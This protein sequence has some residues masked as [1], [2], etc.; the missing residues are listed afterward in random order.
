[1]L[2][3]ARKSRAAL[4]EL[5]ESIDPQRPANRSLME[6]YETQTMIRP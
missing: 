4:D 1:M 6:S 5:I 2:A 3:A